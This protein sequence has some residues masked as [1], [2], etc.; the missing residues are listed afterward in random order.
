LPHEESVEWKCAAGEAGDQWKEGEMGEM[1]EMGD[2]R[3]VR[4][5]RYDRQREKL[6]DTQRHAHGLLV[7]VHRLG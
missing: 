4:Y 7:L 2:G 5:V 3:Y 6:G 1:G